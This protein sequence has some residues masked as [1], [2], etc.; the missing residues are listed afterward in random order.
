MKTVQMR[1]AYMT[2]YVPAMAAI[3]WCVPE[4]LW[5]GLCQKAAAIAIPSRR[6]E[7]VRH[8][9][10]I[11]DGQAS[12]SEVRRIV[13]QFAANRHLSRLQL[14]RCYR[15]GSWRPR[16]EVAGLEHIEQ[17][18]ARGKG[19]ILWVTPFVFSFL[20]TKMALHQRGLRIVHLSHTT[21]GFSQTVFGERV[22]NR[23]WTSIED[24]YLAERLVM[25]PEQSVTALRSLIARV[26][27]NQLISITF[28][29]KGRRQ[30]IESFFNG[31]LP[32]A[33]GATTLACR[34]GAALLPVF[35]VRTGRDVFTTTIEAPLNT[36]AT[37]SPG[38]LAHDCF[39]LL[40][41]YSLRFS[42]QF[43]WGLARAGTTVTSSQDSSGKMPR[44]ESQQTQRSEI[45]HQRK[46]DEER[47]ARDALKR[48]RG[49]PKLAAAHANPER[50]AHER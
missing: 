36:G 43:P 37:M 50:G 22:L 20:V 23:I 11:L 39:S 31:T 7:D 8:V 48:G 26:R 47:E 30:H 4:R 10:R 45:N 34:T 27:E 18:L 42:D 32:V 44:P 5:D 33:E 49:E 15:A 46:H 25:S 17:A 2:G 16:L 40:E 13:T 21:H 14:L 1:D 35:S 28:T 9:A 12:E 19:A 6:Q 38:E 3:S 24:R 29:P 41:S